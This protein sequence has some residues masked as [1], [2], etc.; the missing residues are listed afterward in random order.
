MRDKI[1]STVKRI[2]DSVEITTRFH[3]KG[4]SFPN[5]WHDYFELEIVLDGEYEH[6][7]C[8][9]KRIA[10]RGSAWIM[11]Y[12][13][14]HS[15]VCTRDAK[16]LN[17]GFSAQSLSRD[18][19][20]ALSC[21]GGL[22]C[23]LDSRKTDEIWERSQIA[24]KE[25][26]EKLPFWQIK[27]KSIIESIIIEIIRNGANSSLSS[28]IKAPR[29]LQNV[30]SHIYANYSEDLSLNSLSKIFN[31]SPG[32]LGLIFSKSFGVSV[33][34]YVARVRMKQSCNLLENSE[35]STK[36]I[37]YICGFKSIEYFHYSFKKYMKTTPDS[38][39]KEHRGQKDNIHL[40]SDEG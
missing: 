12:L 10:C 21:A 23:E 20:S 37:A 2:N 22:I 38:Y 17:I 26:N 24:L 33:S 16:I 4:F 15:F 34:A 30:I 29:V 35:L 13:D 32:H 18:I 6:N 14:Y 7:V 39:R 40:I 11:S 27:V 1:D 3:E 25:I 28:N 9:E 8:G 19:A 31:L 5:H 36:E